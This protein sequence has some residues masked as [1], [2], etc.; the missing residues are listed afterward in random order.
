MGPLLKSELGDGPYMAGSKFTA[1][2]I[3]FGYNMEVLYPSPLNSLSGA[4]TQLNILTRNRFRMF[5]FHLL[6]SPNFFFSDGLLQ[7]TVVRG[8][9]A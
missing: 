1:L 6:V 8:R 3:V 2:D 9:A 4:S 7:E 5:K